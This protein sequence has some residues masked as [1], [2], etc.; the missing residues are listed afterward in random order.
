MRVFTLHGGHI[1]LVIIK[2]Q[3][4]HLSLL[5]QEY[6]MLHSVKKMSPLAI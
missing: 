3:T 4:A 5:L 2:E 6:R 1:L